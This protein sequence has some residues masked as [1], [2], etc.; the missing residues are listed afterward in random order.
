[1]PE[2]N[3]KE[4]EKELQEELNA[5]PGLTKAPP[6]LTLQEEP[7]PNPNVEEMVKQQKQNRK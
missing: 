4:I 5:E 2:N 1:M 3:E 7:I 6:Q